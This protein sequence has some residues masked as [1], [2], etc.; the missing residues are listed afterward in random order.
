MHGNKSS[1]T[2]ENKASKNLD[3]SSDLLCW[4]IHAVLASSRIF[5][6]PTF[7]HDK[8]KRNKLLFHNLCKHFSKPCE[9]RNCLYLWTLWTTI[10]IHVPFKVLPCS[11]FLPLGQKNRALYVILLWV[12]MLGN[13]LT[14]KIKQHQNTYTAWPNTVLEIS[15]GGLTAAVTS[16]SPEQILSKIL[17]KLKMH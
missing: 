17:S 14:P 2:C 1:I 9:G 15:T 10:S 13:R 6:V 16:L 3:A 5:T 7:S 11:S 4:P 8:R 12:S